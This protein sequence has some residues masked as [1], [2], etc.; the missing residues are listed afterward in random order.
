MSVQARSAVRFGLHGPFVLRSLTLVCAVLASGQAL[1]APAGNS[2]APRYAARQPIAQQTFVVTDFDAIR[3]EAPV[4]VTVVTGKGGSTAVGSGGR[5]TLDALRLDVN[6]RMLV[7]RL[8]RSALGNY[9]GP[10]APAQLALSTTQLRRAVVMG[11]GSIT[12]DQMKGDRTEVTVQGSGTVNVPR[13]EAGQLTIGLLGSGNFTIGGKV[14]D[15]TATVS[16]SGR[17][18]ASSLDVQRLRLNTEG[19]TDAAF[20]ARDTATVVTTGSGRA[21]VT[22]PATCNV[23]RVGSNSVECGGTRY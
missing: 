4:D 22:G 8:N 5:S 16:G 2:A 12:A 13:I 7:I 17:A 11:A 20:M 10:L 23:R 19:A 9:D 15:V 6:A 1:A 3:L 21:I 18:D 14:N